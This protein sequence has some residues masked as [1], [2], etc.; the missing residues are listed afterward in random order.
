[1]FSVLKQEKTS[2]RDGQ[3]ITVYRRL[4]LCDTVEDMSRLSVGD[5]PGSVA[6]VVSDGGR[7]WLLDHH[8]VWHPTDGSAGMGGGIWS[9]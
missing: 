4:Y 6:V 1:M 5:A 7:V 3:G 8:R 9:I 2:L